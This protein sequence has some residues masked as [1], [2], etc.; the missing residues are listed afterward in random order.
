MVRFGTE[1]ALSQ[2]G[3]GARR[4][5]TDL[6]FFFRLRV[7]PSF[8]AASLLAARASYPYDFEENKRLLAV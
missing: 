2:T 3:T 4:E 6:L 1:N 8:L 7:R 5:N